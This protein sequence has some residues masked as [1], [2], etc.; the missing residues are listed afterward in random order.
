MSENAAATSD[1]RAAIGKLWASGEQRKTK[2]QRAWVRNKNR[3]ASHSHRTAN[4]EQWWANSKK[5]IA[6][7]SNRIMARD[8]NIICASRALD[9][10]KKIQSLMN[11][12]SK[13][14]ATC[15]FKKRSKHCVAAFSSKIC[16]R[17]KTR[18]MRSTHRRK[19]ATFFCRLFCRFF[20][21][22]F[23]EVPTNAD[24]FFCWAY[25]PPPISG[26]VRFFLAI[27]RSLFFFATRLEDKKLDQRTHGKGVWLTFWCS[28]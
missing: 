13:K 24:F 22:K 21:C 17:P 15:A 4:K 8:L 25:P 14:K 7:T 20:F 5:P 16:T 28:S 3:A 11:E 27:R 1:K 2:D 19:S 23:F 12:P 26:H 9:T 6:S 18:T 10:L